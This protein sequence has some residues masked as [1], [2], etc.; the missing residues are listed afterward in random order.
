MD[1]QV[2][3]GVPH[4]RQKLSELIQCPTARQVLMSKVDQ[5]YLQTCK[6]YETG[7]DLKKTDNTSIRTTADISKYFIIFYDIHSN[8]LFI[9][10]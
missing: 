10:C 8:M 4:I 7:F 2:H 3:Q 1:S 5:C 9:A 6:D